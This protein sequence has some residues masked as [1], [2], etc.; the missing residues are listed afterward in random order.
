LT[1]ERIDMKRILLAVA[2]ILIPSLA[3]AGPIRRVAGI[4]KSAASRGVTTVA[5]V[6][7]CAGGQCR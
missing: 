4:G 6:R 5:R 1:T 7:S 2:L 3:E